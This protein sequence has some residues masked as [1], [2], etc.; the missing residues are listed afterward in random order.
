MLDNDY[1]YQKEI[2]KL[3]PKCINCNRAGGTIFS[4][5]FYSN[6]NGDYRE[7]KAICGVISNPCNLNI[8]IQIGKYE[9][10]T[11]I[12]NE[13]ENEIKQYKNEI[14]DEKNK[15]LFGFITTDEAVQ[16]FEDIKDY[17]SNFTSLLNQYLDLYTQIKQ[18]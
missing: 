16:K 12:L 3:K 11:D 4:N 14:I 2:S 13:I 10:L 6:D 18:T 1:H 5:K 8:N 17:I 9:L 15:L 7:L